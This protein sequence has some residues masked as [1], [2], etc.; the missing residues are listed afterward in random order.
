MVSQKSKLGGLP[1]CAHEPIKPVPLGT[2]LK[3]AADCKSGMIMH[4]EVVQNPEQQ[5]RKKCSKEKKSFPEK[6]KILS[7]ASE[8]L[9]QVEGA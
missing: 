4:D 7:H 8:V 3:N 2:I 1:N 6:S 9:R 5:L